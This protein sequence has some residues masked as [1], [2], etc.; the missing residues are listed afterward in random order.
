[1]AGMGKLSREGLLSGPQKIVEATAMGSMADGHF[2]GGKENGSFQSNP[3]EAA[4]LP[5]S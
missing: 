2:W 5:L 4:A 3:P 1:M